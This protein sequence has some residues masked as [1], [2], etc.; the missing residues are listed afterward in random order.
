MFA[1]RFGGMHVLGA[2]PDT[3]LQP[4]GLGPALRA[5]AGRRR[6]LAFSAWRFSRRNK[7]AGATARP[8][9]TRPS[10]RT[11]T[12][13]TSSRTS[14]RASTRERPDR[15]RQT[16]AADDAEARIQHPWLGDLR[17]RGGAGP[18]V[19]R[20]GGRPARRR[21]PGDD[22]RWA[23]WPLALCG[24]ALFRV[25]DPLLRPA[26]AAA[27]AEANRQSVRLRELEREKQLVLKAIREIEH[28]F[29]MR[30]I[31]ESDYKEMT[32]RYRAR[33]MR[34]IQEIDA[35]DDFRSLIE[36]ELKTPAGGHRGGRV[37]VPAARRSTT[38]TRDSARSAAAS[39]PRPARAGH[40]RSDDAVSPP[41]S[42][43]GAVV[44]L[45]FSLGAAPALAQMPDLRTMSGKP[46]PVTDLPPGTVV[47]RVV[48]QSRPTPRWAWRSAPPPAPLPGTHAPASMK[49]GADGRASSRTCPAA[50]SSRPR[51]PSTA[52]RWRPRPSRC[53]SRAGCG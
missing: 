21:R 7:R 4:A 42:A 34:L 46:L 16:S 9:R 45:L 5:G 39:W 48:R 35:G 28:D 32:H 51:S 8:P 49:T 29:Q 19:R 36:Q 12:S 23:G 11:G 38:W 53:R 31:S 6:C 25:V 18:A 52:R 1:E 13:R 47:V 41:S 17:H 10:P 24:L 33:A 20:A 14:F 43:A 37:P 26:A 2:P 30:K 40:D 3:R 22:R 15:R 27:R 50:P 44:G